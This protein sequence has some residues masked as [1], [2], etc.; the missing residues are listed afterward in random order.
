MKMQRLHATR[1]LVEEARRAS[2]RHAA[3]IGAKAW[4][5]ERQTYKRK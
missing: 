1:E 4:E 2:E 5:A 3:V